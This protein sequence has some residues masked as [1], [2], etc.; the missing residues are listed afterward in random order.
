MNTRIVFLPA[1]AMAMLGGCIGTGGPTETRDHAFSGFDSIAAQSGIDVVLVQ[2]PFAVKSEAPEGKLDRIVIAQSGSEL[3]LELKSEITW[4]GYSGRYLVTVSAPAFTAI[5][6]SGG[7]DV[8]A[9]ALQAETLALDASGGGDIRIAGAQI[10]ALVASASGGGDI[11]IAGTCT[12]ATLSASGGGDF[13]GEK[14][15]CDSVTAD[16][17]GGGDID[18][19]ARTTATGKASGGGD[20]RFHGNPATFTKDESPGGD[21]SVEAR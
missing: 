9:S 7:A 16:A 10:G 17:G 18:V 1:V 12:T 13:D 2:G 8:D 3:Q 14:L 15:D 6:A 4:F 21:V 11:S 5:D 20:V 19:G